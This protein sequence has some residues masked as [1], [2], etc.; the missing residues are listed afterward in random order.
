MIAEGLGLY[1]CFVTLLGASQ[2][3][4]QTAT[5]TADEAPTLNFSNNLLLQYA[6]LDVIIVLLLNIILA[7]LVTWKKDSFFEEEQD[8]GYI[9]Q[10]KMNI[11][12]EDYSK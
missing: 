8:D 12:G 2:K 9:L 11:E 1:V 7:I 4:K 6:F 3:L 5:E 10:K